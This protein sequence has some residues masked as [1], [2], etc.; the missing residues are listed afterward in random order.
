M[1]VVV[2]NRFIFLLSEFLSGYTFTVKRYFKYSNKI[3]HTKEGALTWI[4]S[5][6]GQL[7]ARRDMNDSDLNNYEQ[8]NRR[9][10]NTGLYQEWGTLANVGWKLEPQLDGYCRIYTA[11][12]DEFYCAENNR[13]DQ[14]TDSG[15][16]VQAVAFYGEPIA[17]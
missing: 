7:P 14:L 3:Y 12:N 16:I 4:A 9:E 15:Y 13:L 11:E 5:V 1:K 2:V 17:K 6:K 8:Y 10:V